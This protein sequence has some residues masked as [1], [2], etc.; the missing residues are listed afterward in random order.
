[1]KSTISL[2][3]F[4]Q[5]LRSVLDEDFET[6]RL[7][8][9]GGVLKTHQYLHLVELMRESDDLRLVNV[10]PCKFFGVRSEATMKK[11]VYNAEYGGFSLSNEANARLA[12]LGC[13][14]PRD[15][16]RH[17]PRLVSIVEEMGHAAGSP[18]SSLRI[19]HMVGSVYR[20]QSYD[21]LERVELPPGEGW[22]VI[23]G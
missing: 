23:P 12:S 21:G 22:A 3:I 18:M 1:M 9:G 6:A 15:L 7:L 16:S 13:D 19:V 5:A 17:D 10:D 11:V 4:S 20:I 2:E 14:N 8:L